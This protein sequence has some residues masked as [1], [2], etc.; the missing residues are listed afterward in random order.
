[1]L[2]N[3][4]EMLVAIPGIRAPA[5]TATNPAMRAYSTRSCPRL[6][7]Q[8]FNFIIAFNIAVILFSPLS[9]LRVDSFCQSGR[10]RRRASGTDLAGLDG[11]AVWLVMKLVTS[12][13]YWEKGVSQEPA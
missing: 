2:E 6:S 1:M 11:L 5:E 10:F 3:I 8:I 7:D 13:K 12:R 4:V 9:L